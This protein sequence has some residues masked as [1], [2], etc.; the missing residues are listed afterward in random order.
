[1][2]FEVL[3]ERR[4]QGVHIEGNAVDLP[5]W[6]IVKWLKYIQVIIDF[7]NSKITLEKKRK[8]KNHF[9]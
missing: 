7:S 3:W 9:V 2:V 4:Y 6:N 5:L 8:A 1:V